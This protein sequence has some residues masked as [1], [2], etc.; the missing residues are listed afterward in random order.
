MS[1]SLADL[2]IGLLQNLQH[3]DPGCLIGFS[4]EFNGKVGA[5]TAGEPRI[6]LFGSA[7]FGRDGFQIGL[8]GGI[9]ACA[10]CGQV[11]VA[12]GF[13]ESVPF[14][15]ELGQCQMGEG[16]VRSQGHQLFQKALRHGRITELPVGMGQVEMNG[17]AFAVQRRGLFECIDRG[18]GSSGLFELDA[19]I[20]PQHRDIGTG[21]FVR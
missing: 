7:D 20:V 5:V 11:E 3:G 15:K 12:G 1:E 10:G 16:F 13:T 19:E 8:H 6:A 14:L 18:G 2:S 9:F 21:F 4:V 17:R